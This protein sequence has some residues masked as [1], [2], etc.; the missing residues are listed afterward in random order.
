MFFSFKI[1]SPDH[2]A[3]GNHFLVDAIA[4]ALPVG[5][6]A[7]CAGERRGINHIKR[8]SRPVWSDGRH[9]YLLELLA[10]AQ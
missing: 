7:R 1:P 3:Q 6:I 4:I 2:I 5:N 10:A 8:T 9:F